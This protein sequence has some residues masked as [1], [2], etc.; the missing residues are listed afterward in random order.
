[1]KMSTPNGGWHGHETSSQW[2]AIMNS[3][4]AEEREYLID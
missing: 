3:G 4:A 2:D 1:M